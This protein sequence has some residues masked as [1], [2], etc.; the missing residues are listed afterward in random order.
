MLS[1][2]ASVLLEL[3]CPAGRE[4]GEDALIQQTDVRGLRHTDK[5]TICLLNAKLV[6]LRGSG[7]Q[8]VVF[9]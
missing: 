1:L 4:E 2:N 9:R 8:P 5:H 6:N 3:G 7:L